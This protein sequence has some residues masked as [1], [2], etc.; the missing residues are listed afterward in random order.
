MQYW[1]ITA[2]AVIVAVIIAAAGWALYRQR[3]SRYLRDRFGP[4][5]D[6]TITEFG[7]RGRAE[8]ELAHRDQRVR[9][10]KTRQLSLEDREKF[11]AQWKQCQALVVDDPPSAVDEGDKLLTEI[12]R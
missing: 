1:Q 11:R 2:I 6:R 12:L 8:A 9:N 10:L 5:Y 7:D 4:E 3:R